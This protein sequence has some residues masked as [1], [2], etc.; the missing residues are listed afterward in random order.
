MSWSNS[1]F[2]LETCVGLIHGLFPGADVKARYVA[3]LADLLTTFSAETGLFG[4]DLSNE[5]AEYL[6]H[7]LVEGRGFAVSRTAADLFET[8]QTSVKQ[9]PAHSR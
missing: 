1:R 4:P 5:A 3:E 2:A 9:K 8:F 7:E 6:F